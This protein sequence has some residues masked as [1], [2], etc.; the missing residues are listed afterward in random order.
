[1]NS[2][3][4]IDQFKKDKKYY[5]E[6]TNRIEKLIRD[7]IKV[8]NI[9]AHAITSRV[10]EIDSLNKKLLVKSTSDCSKY[11][12][13]SDITDL[14]GIRIITYYENETHEIEKLIKEEFEVDLINSVD[15][16]AQLDPD[17]F[18]Y[19]SKHFVVKLSKK[20]SELPELS[21]LKELS[22][23]I[24]VR[25]ILQH[26]WAENEHKLGYKNAMGLPKEI[27]RRFAR[28]ASLLEIADNKF[29]QIRDDLTNYEEHVK[30]G[31][32][33][34]DD[35]ILLDRI[36]LITFINTDP[37]IKTLDHDI[38]PPKYSITDPSNSGIDNR[39]ESLFFLG[40]QSLGD[41]R[42]AINEYRE[43]ILKFAK[44][45]IGQEEDIKD[46]QYGISLFYL[47]YVIIA[48][49]KNNLLTVE[50]L[51]RCGIG[52]DYEWTKL[53]NEIEKVYKEIE[54]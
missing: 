14:A 41:L 19:L 1:M 34:K 43:R 33:N 26:A 8:R 38:I 48:E 18:G 50:Y 27:K 35:N 5:E 46:F 15:K 12:K 31:I 17:R 24:Q 36:S 44:K 28:I 10:K 29:S 9:K 40:I 49:K 51:E 45:W 4:I 39:I 7:L 22:V 13:L 47:C 54:S 21:Q 2:N 30:E 25:T 52:L 37:I 16:G 20:R 6:F 3:E 23:E 42:R 32:T 11:K 53:A